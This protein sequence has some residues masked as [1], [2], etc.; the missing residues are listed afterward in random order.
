MSGGFIGSPATVPLKE[1]VTSIVAAWTVVAAQKLSAKAQDTAGMKYREF[2]LHILSLFRLSGRIR[3]QG[4]ADVKE[5][6]RK[7]F[8]NG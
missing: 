3:T 8:V 7:A 1:Y 2:M 6:E 5:I 4:A